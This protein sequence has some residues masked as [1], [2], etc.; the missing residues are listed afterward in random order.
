MLGLGDFHAIL[1]Q[2]LER[3]VV[4]RLDFQHRPSRRGFGEA[5]ANAVNG[6]AK[7]AALIP[8]A[9]L[10]PLVLCMQLH[11][12]SPKVIVHA[13]FFSVARLEKPEQAP[14]MFRGYRPA[15]RKPEIAMA[16]MSDQ[17]SAQML[18][19]VF[20]FGFIPIVDFANGCVLR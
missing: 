11:A 17:R 18:A 4:H 13:A 8:A 2:L 3:A 7:M 20:L 19:V 6:T 16:H 14:L 1:N 10:L 5:F 15:K 12:D 9:D